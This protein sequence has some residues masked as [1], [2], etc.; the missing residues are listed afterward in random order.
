M[1]VAPG[2]NVRC[3]FTNAED[4]WD[5]RVGIA[6][7]QFVAVTNLPGLGEGTR[8]FYNQILNIV[9][10][11]ALSRRATCSDMAP[12]Y[13]NSQWATN[14][15]GCASNPQ[16]AR[17]FVFNV[18]N[19]YLRSNGTYASPAQ[20]AIAIDQA[21]KS[22]FRRL[23]FD[24]VKYAPPGAISALTT[25]ACLALSLTKDAAVLYA[26]LLHFQRELEPNFRRF[27]EAVATPEQCLVNSRFCA[28]STGISSVTQCSR[29]SRRSP[30]LGIWLN[31]QQGSHTSLCHSQR[32]ASGKMRFN[33][34][35]SPSTAERV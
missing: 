28:H 13:A 5:P 17:C 19:L 2:E 6:A 4:L 18:F 35:T 26:G 16:L 27:T 34:V 20:E 15:I 14:G 33:A 1:V 3:V 23:C 24:A 10:G 25:A 9:C 21:A 29:G 31:G 32:S 22:G 12:R 8:G 30:K 11:A 7:S